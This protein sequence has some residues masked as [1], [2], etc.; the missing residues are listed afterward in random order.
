MLAR[1]EYDLSKQQSDV[2][3]RDLQTHFDLVRQRVLEVLE[4]MRTERDHLIAEADQE[5]SDWTRSFRTPT[6]SKTLRAKAKS[7]QKLIDKGE[8]F[9]QHAEK[10]HAVF[11]QGVRD[12]EL[13]ARL[14]RKLKSQ[15]NSRSK[16]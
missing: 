8:S 15:R 4:D 5:K 7:L 9:L 14:R 13:Q 3:E 1:P 16:K 11:A 6:D 2:Q 12:P 10:Q